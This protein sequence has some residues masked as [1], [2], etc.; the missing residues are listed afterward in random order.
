MISPGV[1]LIVLNFSFFGLLEGK[2]EKYS[3]KWKLLH[4][5]SQEQYILWSWILPH[6][7]KMMISPG[8]FV[9][10]FLVFGF[11]RLLGREKG[12]KWPRV[13]KKF[14]LLHFISQEPY[15]IWLS[16]MVHL[17]KMMISPGVFFNFSQFWFSELLGPKWEKILSAMLHILGIIH[18]MILIYGTHV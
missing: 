16:F 15:I 2:G 14:C 5:L 3:P 8:F 1:F 7:C 6:L 12:K 4:A 18:C 13:T 17:C 10:V 9:V 11:S